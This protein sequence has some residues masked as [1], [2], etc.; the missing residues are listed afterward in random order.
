M[1]CCVCVI[2]CESSLIGSML[3]TIHDWAP[4][5]SG[6]SWLIW[7]EAFPS[8]P[9]VCMGAIACTCVCVCVCVCVCACVCI[10]GG[11]GRGRAWWLDKAT[12]RC[13]HKNT[14]SVWEEGYRGEGERGFTTLLKHGNLFK[15]P[16]L[17]LEQ[18]RP[19]THCLWMGHRQDSQGVE[20][21]SIPLSA[22]FWKG[23]RSNT[24][25]Y[26]VSIGDFRVRIPQLLIFP[27]IPSVLF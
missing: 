17:C 16:F 8:D 9:C 10:D 24:N 4:G 21:V 18:S 3:Q 13:H 11:P 23:C 1:D 15:P 12:F 22:L 19:I 26:L 25:N 14:P 5:V 27:N 2:L 7:M 20:R 6:C